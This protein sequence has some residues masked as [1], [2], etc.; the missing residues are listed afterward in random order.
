MLL[1]CVTVVLLLSCHC[2]WHVHCHPYVSSVRSHREPSSLSSPEYRTAKKI[3]HRRSRRDPVRKTQ[4]LLLSGSYFHKQGA[5]NGWRL[6]AYGLSQEGAP[7]GL[8]TLV[9]VV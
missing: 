6:L 4:S 7:G 3:T 1:L 8:Q 2:Y 9:R 5:D